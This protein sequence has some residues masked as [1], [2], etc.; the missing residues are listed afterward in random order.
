MQR[1]RS[2]GR[3]FHVAPAK[4]RGEPSKRQAVQKSPSLNRKLL[5]TAILAI[6]M[7]TCDGSGSTTSPGTTSL[8]FDVTQVELS[9]GRSSQLGLSNTGS[10]AVG[11]IRFVSTP[12]LDAQGTQVAG[13]S[14]SVPAGDIA[15][16]TPG[17]SRQI[18]AVVTDEGLLPGRYT[19]VLSAVVGSAAMATVTLAFD[20]ATLDQPD[21]ASLVITSGPTQVTQGDLVTYRAE[22]RSDG[23]TVVAGTTVSWFIAP[24]GVTGLVRAD[25]GFVAYEAGVAR[26]VAVAG[27]FA[28]TIEVTV[29]ARNLTGR[30]D[31]VGLGGLPSGRGTTDLWVHGTH[32]YTG[33]LQVIDNGVVTPG[34][35]LM[36]WDISDPTAPVLTDSVVVDA[37]RVND[38]K[39]RDDGTLAVLTHEQSNDGQNGIT[40]LDLTDPAHPTVTSRFT[41]GL[42]T[43]IHNVWIEGDI[44]YVVV[45]GTGNGMRVLDISDPADPTVVASFSLPSSFLH[46]IYGRDG[47]L[48]LSYWNEGLVIMDV[49]HG[50]RGGTPA[51]PRLVSRVRTKGGQ[52]HNA[53]YWPESGYVFIG[54]EDFATPGIMHV[55]DASDLNNPVEVATFRVPGQP[56]HNFWL[57]EEKGVLYQ[58][59]Y[60][61]GIRALDVTGGLAGE[62]ERQ[63]REITFSLYEGAQPGPTRAWA[64]QLH[65]GILYVSDISSGLVV[66]QPQF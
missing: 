31:F 41:T 50:I 40:I 58:A 64:V 63:G 19:T 44:V 36:V 6:S 13:A 21:V 42:E 15:T 25:G 48:F 32:A 51:D 24:G 47:L 43:G 30:L 34:N 37:R 39:I 65:E 16:L 14:L 9:E 60:Q 20:V 26:I 55:V 27:V 5:L 18:T 46:D 4:G 52:A 66:L 61:N 29:V 45:D 1:G 2:E 12:V 3:I 33:T 10:E 28:D 53:W 62:L 8:A 35:A 22:A 7:A 17:T 23:G 38:I 49:G 56:P 57:D 11:P 54:E 59:W